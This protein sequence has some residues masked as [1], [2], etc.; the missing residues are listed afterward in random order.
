M[1]NLTVIAALIIL[2]TSGLPSIAGSYSDIQIGFPAPTHR[3]LAKFYFEH[4]DFNE[5]KTL[6]RSEFENSKF[7]TRIESFDAMKPNENGVVS[8]DGFIK[9][10]V[11]TNKVRS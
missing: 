4:M 10:Y 11:E 3:E 7:S 2:S 9:Y 6:D 8:L 5:D 1:K